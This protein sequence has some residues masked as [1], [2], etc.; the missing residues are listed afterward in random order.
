[1]VN[2]EAIRVAT[3]D[4]EPAI[5]AL[6]CLAFA[7]DPMVRGLFSHPADYLAANRNYAGLSSG[8][9]FDQSSAYIIGNLFGAALW[10]PPAVGT[11]QKPPSSKKITG[12]ESEID[13]D[14]SLLLDE[15]R[16][17]RP[18]EPHWCLSLIAVDPI[19]HGKGYGTALL[20]HGLAICDKDKH[21]I[22]L[23][24]TNEANVPLYKRFGFNLLSTVK[25]NQLSRYPMLRQPK[26]VL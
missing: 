1:M 14:V 22:Y 9:A 4:D 16:S 7:T 23:E 24:S 19:L 20:S 17:Y 25:V 15:A 10:L 3:W 13:K 2:K 21:P 11:H 8:I 18:L 12:A 5:S 6:L 26:A